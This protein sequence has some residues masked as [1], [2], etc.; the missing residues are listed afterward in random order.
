MEEEEN[1]DTNGHD[2]SSD[3]GNVHS[4]GIT[5]EQLS[6]AF[7]T[8]V[9]S[10]ITKAQ[11]HSN[12][13][14][15]SDNSL[16]S[17]NAAISSSVEMSK[18]GAKS[19]RGKSAFASSVQIA[20]PTKEE[21]EDLPWQTTSKALKSSSRSEY[22][23][24]TRQSGPVCSSAATLRI[25]S[26]SPKE[27]LDIHSSLHQ[28]SKDNWHAG[29]APLMFADVNTTHL[30]GSLNLIL[31]IVNIYEPF[32]TGFKHWV[33][34]E[35]VIMLHIWETYLDYG[36]NTDRSNK[37]EIQATRKQFDGM[38]STI[39]WITC[40]GF[41]YS[42]NLFVVSSVVRDASDEAVPPLWFNYLYHDFN[43]MNSTLGWLTCLEFCY[44]NNLFV[45]APV[46][47]DASDEAG[48]SSLWFNSF[49][50]DTHLHVF[51]FLLT[52]DAARETGLRLAFHQDIDVTSNQSANSVDQEAGLASYNELLMRNGEESSV[53]E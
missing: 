30:Q 27:V 45:V 12:S 23:Y 52:T 9:G 17:G 33:H 10:T 28:G 34:M 40:Q 44:P 19:D 48:F 13:N 20:L 31:W 1:I 49:H 2:D 38:N 25:V 41:I 37:L 43:G 26:N 21:I 24:P 15:S 36:V 35:T 46:V 5:N 7:A 3:D 22:Y 16:K 11:T 32:P 42:D 8:S 14:K 29:F 53:K 18:P 51:A 50:R 6:S 4:D 47:Q 39:G